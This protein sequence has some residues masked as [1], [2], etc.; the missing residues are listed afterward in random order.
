MIG[1]VVFHMMRSDPRQACIGYTLARAHWGQGYATEAV[2]GLLDYLFRELHLHRVVAECDVLNTASH[3][4]LERLGFRREAHFVDALW[5]KGR[6][7]SE[8][9]YALLSKEWLMR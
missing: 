3:K 8:Y 7:S 4:L 1:D 6:W 2:H 9:H 5:F